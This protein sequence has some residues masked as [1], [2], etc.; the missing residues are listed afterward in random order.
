MLIICAGRGR[1]GSTLLYNLIRITLETI[2]G[3]KNV[4]G[5]SHR[6]YKKN[7][8]SK[9]HVVKIHGHDNYLWEKADFIFSSNRNEV[10]QK[11]SIIKFRKIIKNQDLTSYELNEFLKIDL[12][13]F[14]KWQGHKKFKK[15]FP[16]KQLTKNKPEVIKEICKILNLNLENKT[17]TII[18]NVDELKIPEKKGMNKESCLI[19]HHFTSKEN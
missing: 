1:S 14:Q 18:K 12:N 2:K 8:P 10:D 13:R 9:Y 6:F 3:K 17:E 15:V 5:R 16:F 4:Y 7:N 11:K 19:Y